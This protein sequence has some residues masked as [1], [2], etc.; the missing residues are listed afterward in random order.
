MTPTIGYAL[1]VL[2]A[3]L[4][5][6]WLVGRFTG[7]AAAATRDLAAQ[8]EALRKE[9]ERSA[10]ELAAAKAQIERARAELEQYRTSVSDHFAGASDRFRDLSLQYR[11]LF[12][13]LSE[14]ARALCGGDFTALDGGLSAGALP[15]QT[16]AGAGAEVRGE[17]PDA[18]AA[19]STV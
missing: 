18:E 5:G 4:V 14:G 12:D 11:S 1:V 7:K 13:H 16:P 2:A 8:V 10:A 15:A 9:S 6:G 19:T 17:T 3:A